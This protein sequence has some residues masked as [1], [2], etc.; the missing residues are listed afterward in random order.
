VRDPYLSAVVRHVEG[1]GDP[2]QVT[3]ALTSG[4]LVTG[5]VRQAAFFV[6]VT[7]HRAQELE[8]SKDEDE[9]EKPRDVRDCRG[10]GRPDQADTRRR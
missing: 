4:A 10:A 9:K 5:F 2:V 6:S 7:R 3:L 8:L 1:G